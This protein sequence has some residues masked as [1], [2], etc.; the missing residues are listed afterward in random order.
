MPLPR[1]ELT[2]S[3]DHPDPPPTKKKKKKKVQIQDLA[4]RCKIQKTVIKT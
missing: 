3:E 2:T 4:M 1:P